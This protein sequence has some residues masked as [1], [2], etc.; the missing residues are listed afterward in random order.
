[1]VKPTTGFLGKTSE[2][3]RRSGRCWL[4]S[5]KLDFE[6]FLINVERLADWTWGFAVSLEGSSLLLLFG[7]FAGGDDWILQ[8]ATLEKDDWIWFGTGS[9][10]F[11]MRNANLCCK[12]LSSLQTWLLEWQNYKQNKIEKRIAGIRMVSSWRTPCRDQGRSLN[13]VIS[14]K[15]CPACSDPHHQS[16]KSA[17]S[18][19]LPWA[20]S[21]SPYNVFLGRSCEA[22]W[23]HQELPDPNPVLSYTKLVYHALQRH[24]EYLLSRHPACASRRTRRSGPP[25]FARWTCLWSRQKQAGASGWEV[26]IHFQ[27]QDQ[28]TL[29]PKKLPEN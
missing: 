27:N 23:S 9:C 8:T 12:C 7:L 10:P 28:N 15:P 24:S 14:M 1:M 5:W 11:E 20:I 6:D 25:S 19:D 2:E 13:H 17:R 21:W 22:P 29:K 18:S 26:Q 4:K 3:N 16:H